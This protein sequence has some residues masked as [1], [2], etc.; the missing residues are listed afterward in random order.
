[1]GPPLQ[2]HH[3]LLSVGIN[4]LTLQAILAAVDYAMSYYFITIF[5]FFIYR[6]ID[7]FLRDIRSTSCIVF[8]M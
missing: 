2:L 1:M 3:H 8:G 6:S 5:T 7:G 4:T